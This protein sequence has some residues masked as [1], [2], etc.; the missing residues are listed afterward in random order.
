MTLRRRE[1]DSP[2][3]A[4]HRNYDQLIEK[5]DSF[6]IPGRSRLGQAEQI[7]AERGKFVTPVSGR[8]SDVAGMGK[9]T[10]R[11]KETPRY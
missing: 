11:A 4:I 6:Q 7:G 9:R 1:Y 2:M 5:I 10:D 8:F 3:N